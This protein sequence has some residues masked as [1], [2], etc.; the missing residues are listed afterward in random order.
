[1][2]DRPGLPAS[3]Q[4]SFA[5]LRYLFGLAAFAP[6]GLYDVARA[7]LHHDERFAA[8]A[9]V[10]RIVADGGLDRHYPTHWPARV[11]IADRSGA[12]RTA[13]VI[14]APGDPEH[15]LSWDEV[16]EKFRRV[17]GR[18]RETVA[19]IASACQA[20]AQTGFGQ[21]FFAMAER[22]IFGADL[23]AVP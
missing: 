14:H 10:I 9:P 5:N 20:L 8:L 18:P 15:P 1:M 12:S 16:R 22:E 4:E 3:R 13:E 19:R 2:I 23:T 6:D 11:T 17:T 7:T 21:D